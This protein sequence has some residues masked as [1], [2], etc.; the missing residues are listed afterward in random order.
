MSGYLRHLVQ[1][2]LSAVTDVRPRPASVFETTGLSL[3]PGAPPSE[4]PAT[5]RRVLPDNRIRSDRQSTSARGPASQTAAPAVDVAPPLDTAM[6]RA[7]EVEASRPASRSN[8]G[9]DSRS[10][11]PTESPPLDAAPPIARVSDSALDER[12]TTARPV[13]P[14][15]P[16]PPVS[17]TDGDVLPPTPM[18]TTRPASAES[19]NLPARHRHPRVTQPEF[20]HADDVRT[21]VARVQTAQADAVSTETVRE[22]S[23]DE[24]I[25]PASQAFLS[26]RLPP[27][28]PAARPAPAPV[29]AAA[30]PVVNVTIGRVEIRA[31]PAPAAQKRPAPSKPTLSLSDYLDRRSGDRG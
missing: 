26:P 29:V 28:E 18:T 8:A 17:E 14:Q 9:S 20:D 2:S 25:V 5:Q 30:E 12:D 23:R 13:G 4:G 31:V 15:A 11:G 6:R 7:T 16:P 27:P 22:V 1:R 3:A 19:P 21:A 10:R 24:S